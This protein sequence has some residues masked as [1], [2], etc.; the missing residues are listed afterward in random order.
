MFL[1]GILYWTWFSFTCSYPGFNWG[2]NVVIFGVDNSL[3][4]HTDNKKKDI[5]VLG[6]SQIQR[7][8][9]GN[10]TAEA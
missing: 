8:N 10:I 7:L 9:D 5:L 6:E 4:V 2:Q 1:F 3:S